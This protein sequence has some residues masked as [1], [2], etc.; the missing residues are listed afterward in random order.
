MTRCA[1]IATAVLLA[2]AG[3]GTSGP[4]QSENYGNLLTSPGT[5]S[6]TTTIVCNADS[7]C[8]AGQS[9]NGLILVEEEHP[10]GWMRPNCFGCHNVQLIHTVNRTGL[11]DA[12][13]NL[14]GVRA[15]VQNEG[16]AS[17]P[18]CH[19]NNGVSPTPASTASET[20]P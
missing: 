20:A 9:C 10:T 3:C 2:I 1:L 17:C 8:P 4:V 11:P 7:D 18:L 15:I 13:V 12:E 19:G 5:C 14:A 16:V 6:T